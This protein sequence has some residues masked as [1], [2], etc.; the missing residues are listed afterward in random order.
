MIEQWK[1]DATVW[2]YTDKYVVQEC[3][4]IIR[5]WI[6]IAFLISSLSHM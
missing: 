6:Y 2:Q 5:E 4:F 1:I 3:G